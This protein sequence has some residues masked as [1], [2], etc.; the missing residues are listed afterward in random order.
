MDLYI[1]GT[2]NIGGYIAYHAKEMGD[3]DLKGFIDSDKT[4]FNL[5]FC[6]FPVL[7][8]IDILDEIECQ[9]AIAVAIANPYIK[10]RIAM[11][12]R[13]NNKIHFPNFVHPHTW[14]SEKTVLGEG[15]I[16][17]PGVSINYGCRIGDFVTINMNAAI[18]HD[19]EL[20]D[21]STISPGVNLGGFTNVGERSFIG[22]GGNTLQSTQIG[23]G[24]T[25][26]G[27]AMVISNIPDGITVVGNP[28]REIRK[29]Q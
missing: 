20:S 26:G 17:Y 6:E 14:V 11:I 1:I 7:G 15:V 21:F 5:T 9:V 29:T 18:G 22:I 13:K 28:A 10:E 27:G 19:C 3:Y 16:I 24:C 8:D 12:L 23:K 4:K 2:G 25:I